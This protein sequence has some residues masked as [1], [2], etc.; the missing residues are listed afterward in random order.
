MRSKI[1]VLG[2]LVF[3]LLFFASPALSQAP[4]ASGAGGEAKAP[5]VQKEGTAQDTAALCMDALN[6]TLAQD[7]A[8]FEVMKMMRAIVIIQ[9][10]MIRGI[11]AT[12]KRRVQ[13]ELKMMR[14]QLER[15]IAGLEMRYRQGRDT[16]PPGAQGR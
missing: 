15:M 9:D 13:G 5:P 14:E 11:M 7:M 10:E 12:D 1:T 3:S 4:A 8:L 6:R 2:I 16:A